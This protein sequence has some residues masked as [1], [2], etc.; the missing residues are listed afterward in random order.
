MND[1]EEIKRWDV[2]LT[3]HVYMIW[4]PCVW[5]RRQC[6]EARDGLKSGVANLRNI[7]RVNDDGGTVCTGLQVHVQGYGIMYISSGV[8]VVAIDATCRNMRVNALEA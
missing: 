6:G 5:T 7:T 1:I 4:A 3:N 2:G 8:N